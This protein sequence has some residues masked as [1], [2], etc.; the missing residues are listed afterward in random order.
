[1][2]AETEKH[3]LHSIVGRISVTSIVCASNIPHDN[4]KFKIS[5]FS[6][7]TRVSPY[8][9]KYKPPIHIKS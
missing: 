2:H 7:K 3:P 1:L 5:I 6:D 4:T 8:L 9:S